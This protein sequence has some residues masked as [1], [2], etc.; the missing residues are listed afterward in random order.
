MSGQRELD[1]KLNSLGFL[2][3]GL[4]HD[5]GNFISAIAVTAAMIKRQH[6]DETVTQMHCDRI[7]LAC[8]KISELAHGVIDYV[9]SDEAPD[10]S[11]SLNQIVH[12]AALLLETLQVPVCIDLEPDLTPIR[13]DRSLVYVALMNL[14]TNA[15]QALQ[16][17][18][19]IRVCTRNVS[20]PA[21]PGVR[22]TIVDDGIGMSEEVVRRAFEPLFTARPDGGGTGM[23]LAIV[24]RIIAEHGGEISL[25]SVPGDGTRVDVTFPASNCS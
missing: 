7:H 19:S 5:I 15:A 24:R 12:E 21:G 20:R 1:D 14:C 22:I 10:A 4:A 8:D 17:S 3:C 23:G 16:Q 13:G 11:F 9:K 6:P 18:G 2:A 25:A